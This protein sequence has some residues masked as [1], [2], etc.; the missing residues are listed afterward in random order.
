VAPTEQIG[1]EK[2]LQRQEENFNA[3][4]EAPSRR[5]CDGANTWFAW[6]ANRVSDQYHDHCSGE[7]LIEPGME[8]DCE[9]FVA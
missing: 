7:E 5:H 8:G 9:R 2:F 3:H 4:D 6:N 1:S